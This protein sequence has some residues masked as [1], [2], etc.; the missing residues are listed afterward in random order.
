MKPT[1]IAPL[2]TSLS[3]MSS[4]RIC[5]YGSSSSSTPLAYIKEAYSLGAVLAKRCAFLFSLL[6]HVAASFPSLP[7]FAYLLSNRESHTLLFSYTTPRGHICVNGGGAHGC[8][9]AMNSGCDASGGTIHAVIHDMFV[10]DGAEYLEGDGKGCRV[11]KTRH[12]L[13]VTTG[14]NLKERKEKLVENVDAIIVL[15]GG[16]GTFDELWEMAAQ[17]G[18]GSSDEA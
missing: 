12:S 11:A 4:L 15:P 2:T 5:C 8:M 3:I 10:V 14:P 13:T 7:S 1:K 9:G 16:T 18:E 6:I 17:R